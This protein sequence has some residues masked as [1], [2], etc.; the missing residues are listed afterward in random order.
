MGPVAS[1]NLYTY[2]RFEYKTIPDW[3]LGSEISAKHDSHGTVSNIFCPFVKFWK[4]YKKISKSVKH[5][6]NKKIDL[7]LQT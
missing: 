2:V 3:Y 1:E 7:R 5:K 4:I 6:Q